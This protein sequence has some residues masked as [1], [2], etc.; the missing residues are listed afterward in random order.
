ML[1][2]LDNQNT[3]QAPIRENPKELIEVGDEVSIHGSKT[4]IVA[5]T[6]GAVLSITVSVQKK[7]TLTQRYSHLGYVLGNG[8]QG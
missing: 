2:S 4:G 5:H 1:T 7:G 3:K 6:K 8:R